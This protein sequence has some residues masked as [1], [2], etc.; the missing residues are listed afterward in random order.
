VSAKAEKSS[1]DGIKNRYMRYDHNGQLLALLG[2]AFIGASDSAQNSP[3]FDGSISTVW[4]RTVSERR[5]DALGRLVYEGQRGLQNASLNDDGSANGTQHGQI[6]ATA[7]S[8]NRLD[9]QVYSLDADGGLTYQRHDAAGNLR[10][11]TRYD[12]RLT[13]NGSA[14][15]GSAVKLN[16][17][18][19]AEHWRSDAQA[20]RSNE[21]SSGRTT[22]YQY[23]ANNLVTKTESDAGVFFDLN[24]LV[25]PDSTSG[26]Q[27]EL[28]NGF[29]LGSTQSSQ[30]LYDANGNPIIQIDGKDQASFALYDSA[31]NRVLEVDR[32][33]YVTE[34]RY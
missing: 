27:Q 11:E 32:L 4:I 12:Q 1:A 22:H 7:Y 28:Q 8:Y 16:L 10:S 3:D 18:N 34:Y 23:N 15:D 31:G 13:L 29:S 25:A 2:P 24:N 26:D 9:Q 14:W 19:S 17:D 30:A 6:Q 21:S 33:G 20:L 5:Y